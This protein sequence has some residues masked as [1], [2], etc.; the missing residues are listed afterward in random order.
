MEV[1]KLKF[2]SLDDKEVPAF[3]INSGSSRAA[4]VIHGY[5]S[6]KYE[7]LGLGY[8]IAERGYDVYV[9]DLRGHGENENPLD[10]GVINDVEGVM[11]EL[12]KKYSY[13]I[14][15]GHSLGGLLSLKS[16]SD[17]AIAISPP[18]FSEVPSTAKFML[19]TY[20]CKV[21]EK[22]EEVLFRILREYNPVERDRNAVII[23]GTGES[24]GMKMGIEAWSRGRSVEVIFLDKSQATPPEIDVECEELKRY[25]PHF[26]SHQATTHAFIHVLRSLV[27]QTLDKISQMG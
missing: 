9:I 7:L 26:V 25:I 24:R 27:R 3:F 4:I 23:C 13:V 11:R 19:R 5:S 17:F 14:T 22:D 2:K 1:C 20:S 12:R 21:R 6:S 10:E 8:E 16:S 18:L 15:I